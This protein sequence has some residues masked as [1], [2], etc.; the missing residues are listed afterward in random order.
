MLI[1]AKMLPLKFDEKQPDKLI[2]IA[3]DPTDRRIPLI[4]RNFGGKK[5]EV[6][7]C[8]LKDLQN[9]LEQVIPPENE[10]LKLLGEL[11]RSASR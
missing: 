10:F 7:Y 9:L 1:Q 6:A 3:A 4:A 5:Y 2:I 8:R 11:A